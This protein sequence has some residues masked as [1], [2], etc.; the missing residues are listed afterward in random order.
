MIDHTTA[1]YCPCCGQP[2][3]IEGNLDREGLTLKGYVLCYGGRRV[4][5]RPGVAKFIRPLMERGTASHEL[6]RL[7]VCPES[8]SNLP[9]VY[10]N[11]LRKQLADLTG[12]AVVLNTIHSWGYELAAAEQ[13]RAA[14]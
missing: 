6:I 7:R 4:R 1:D 11:F 3:E 13:Q 12:G 10:A 9:Q 5:L 2:R 14:A 8:E